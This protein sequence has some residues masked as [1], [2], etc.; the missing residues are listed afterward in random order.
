MQPEP[1]RCGVCIV[2]VVRQ[3]TGLMIT[4]TERPNVDDASTQHQRTLTDVAQVVEA[5]RTFILDVAR[6]VSDLRVAPVT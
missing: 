4:L 5:I 1:E 6:Q 2:R 3:G